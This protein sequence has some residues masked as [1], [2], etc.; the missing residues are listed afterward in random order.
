MRRK[1]NGI[2]GKSV[3]PLSAP[4]CFLSASP[5]SFDPVSTTQKGYRKE[6]KG[7]PLRCAKGQ[8]VYQILDGGGGVIDDTYDDPAWKGYI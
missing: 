8:V 6:A 5:F 3:S 2:D 4:L 7:Y 1:P